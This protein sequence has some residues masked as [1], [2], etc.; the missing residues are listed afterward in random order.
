M[1][2]ATR[3]ELAERLASNRAVL[4]DTA[5]S[6]AG[7]IA[8][9]RERV[10]TTKAAAEAAALAFNKATA[11]IGGMLLSVES[12][13]TADEKQLRAT[14]PREIGE[15]IERVEAFWA[16][17]RHE[18]DGDNLRTIEEIGRDV[19]R[20]RCEFREWAIEGDLSNVNVRI[21]DAMQG[22]VD[23]A[24]K[25]NVRTRVEQLLGVT[26]GIGASA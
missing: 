10:E 5:R 24:H 21:A 26:P 12:A 18:C 11:E 2:D 20:L 3:L 7:K 1:S 14:A 15:A 25:A 22:L 4:E 8:K 16:A 13:I 17:I 9:L 23:L 19:V 6:S